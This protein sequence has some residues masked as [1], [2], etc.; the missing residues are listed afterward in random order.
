MKRKQTVKSI[1][2][3]G[4][5]NLSYSL[6]LATMYKD[7]GDKCQITAT[8]YDSLEGLKAKYGDVKMEETI[9]TLVSLK[10]KVLHGV[11]ATSLSKSLGG[12]KFDL[13]IFM[14]PLVPSD[15][16]FAFIQSRG[17]HF[18]TVII[19]RLMI[20]K[21]LRSAQ[22]FLADDN[23]EIH[24]TMKNVYPYSWWRID[25]LAA[26]APP[27]QYLACVES[28][29]S[30]LAHY[31][32]RNVERD[33]PFPLTASLTFIYGQRPPQPTTERPGNFKCEVCAC[34]FSGKGDQG[35]HNASKKHQKRVDLEISW[36]EFLKTSKLD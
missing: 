25:K 14:H 4:D 23:S 10:A 33:Q 6:S 15:E 12:M 7:D 30:S 29:T 11:D 24:I 32:S 21:F 1:L 34:R 27:L 26:L 9:S 3:V 13:I 35:K 16:R 19:N 8:T 31:E 28:D 17:D 22:P 20:T 36:T 5:G 18:A 2:T